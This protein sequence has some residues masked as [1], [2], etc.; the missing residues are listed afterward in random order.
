[1]NDVISQRLMKTM[2]IGHGI[3]EN[4]GDVVFF[5]ELAEGGDRRCQS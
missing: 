2:V 3:E 1:M 4:H 5:F